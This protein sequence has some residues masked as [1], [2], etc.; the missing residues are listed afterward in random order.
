MFFPLAV[1]IKIY[2]SFHGKV[3]KK[4]FTKPLCIKFLLKIIFITL[5]TA[6]LNMSL[7]CSFVMCFL[8]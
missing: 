1:M 3:D 5:G 4:L 6:R 2:W 7:Y 8:L